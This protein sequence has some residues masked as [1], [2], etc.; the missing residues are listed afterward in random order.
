[1][2]WT[3]KHGAGFLIALLSAVM[4][5]PLV[6]DT[7][8]QSDY[9]WPTNASRS[10][11]SS[12]AETRPTH[13][14]SG[15][16]IKTWGR[17]GYKVF[18]TR[19]GYIWRIR[20]SPFGYGKVIYQVLDTGEIAVYAHL[21]DFSPQLDRIIKRVQQARKRFSVTKVFKPY[22]LPV[23]KGDMIAYTGSTGIGVPHLHFEI[24]EKANL[25]IN[26]L[27]RGFKLKD[28]LAPRP[29]NLAIMPMGLGSQIDGQPAAKVF[30]LNHI[31][32]NI[33]SLTGPVQA[34]GVIG[35]AVSAY[36]Q[37]N[38]I[39]NKFSPYRISM[40]LDGRTIF[41]ATYD[42]YTFERTGEI[43]LDRNTWLFAHHGR[44]FHNLFVERGNNLPFYAS[45]RQEE[46]ILYSLGYA[47]SL[48]RQTEYL[49][50]FLEGPLSESP[51]AKFDK[52][53]LS[54]I[55]KPYEVVTPGKHEINIILEDFNGNEAKI[56]VDLNIGQKI[57]PEKQFLSFSEFEEVY[58]GDGADLS[59]FKLDGN[60]KWRELQQQESIVPFGSSRSPFEG[61]NFQSGLLAFESPALKITDQKKDDFP[62]YPMFVVPNL[63]LGKNVVIN[64]N[65]KILD[66]KAVIEITSDQPVLSPLLLEMRNSRVG[67]KQ[68]KLT[69]HSLTYFTASLPAVEI[70]QD[71][72]TFLAYLETSKKPLVESTFLIHRLAED[73]AA[74]LK[75]T[76][77]TLRIPAYVSNQSWYLEMDTVDRGDY[78]VPPPGDSLSPVFIFRDNGVPLLKNMRLSI[79]VPAGTLSPEQIGVYGPDLRKK[80]WKHVSNSR[81]EKS[82][83]LIVRT[84]SLGHFT[85]IRDNDPPQIRF[86]Y[87]GKNKTINDHAPLIRI[88]F[89]D[90]LSGLGGEEDYRITL[91]GN[92][93][94]AELDPEEHQIKVTI[95]DPLTT[96][97]HNLEVWMRDRAQNEITS[98]I[99]F[100]VAQ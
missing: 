58:S 88:Q 76:G 42:R 41:S 90:E 15:I 27:L 24:R 3:K 95:E 65:V 6:E 10:L 50:L 40:N 25:P 84:K 79:P 85:L 82:G 86:V 75:N 69:A 23:T 14:H 92:F 94:I 17:E 61:E 47:D 70:S 31:R 74:I 35:F 100:T 7:R 66:P 39:S 26:P 64:L 60:M 99:E 43:F 36:D 18:A 78:E 29:T 93:C 51:M 77:T 11:T 89:S 87:P 96:G 44:R 71:S 33:Y 55:K 4:F 46:G 45:L 91:D 12:F 53:Y 30:R 98:A 20:V 52:D 67:R 56:L 5:G 1:M 22:E 8:A 62:T 59:F 13:F 73:Q 16:D 48:A 21:K 28:T 9:L 97:S 72:T 63:P 57:P 38:G 37:A 49:S 81:D 54:E 80:E 32:E 68:L 83:D 34:W 19:N 2:D